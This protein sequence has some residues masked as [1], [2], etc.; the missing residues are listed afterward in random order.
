[1]ET[2]IVILISYLDKVFEKI[3]FKP[4]RGQKVFYSSSLFIVFFVIM[5]L[6]KIHTFKGMYKYAQKNIHI[7]GGQNAQLGKQ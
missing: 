7:L 4:Q 2:N 3:T 6:K 5:G 1:M